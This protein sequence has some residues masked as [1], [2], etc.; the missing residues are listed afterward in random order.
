MIEPKEALDWGMIN[1]VVSTGT[2]YGQAVN[3]AKEIVKF[4]QE[5]L[6]ADRESTLHATFN[7]HNL[8]E[9][10]GFESEN[11]AKVLTTEAVQ[12]AKKF[13]AG[14]GRSGKFNVNTVAEPQQWQKELEQLKNKALVVDES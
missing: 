4:P 8:E 9:A 13:T 14:L 10:M 11:A 12:G 1:R 3:L 2:A 7:S 6:R 5:C